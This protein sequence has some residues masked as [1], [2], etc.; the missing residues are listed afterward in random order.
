MSATPIDF[1]PFQLNLRSGQLRRDG[2]PIPL[3]PKTFAVLQHLVE[4]PGEL[5]TKLELLDAVWPGIAVGEDVVRISVGELRVT[6]GDARATPRF[7]ETVP[8]R[9]Y[10]FIAKLG[11]T[12]PASPEL[13][14]T[15]CLDD[16][17]VGRT[18]ER[19][20]IAEWMSVAADR[21]SAARLRHGE[22]RD[23]Q[24]YAR[25]RGHSRSAAVGY[26]E[27]PRRARAMHRAIR[28]RRALQAGPRGPRIEPFAPTPARRMRVIERLAS[29]GID[30]G[31]SIVPMI[32]GFFQP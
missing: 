3:R 16:L 18:H 25:R 26:D 14:P 29:A 1:P 8:R 11:D 21:A 23:R 5:V 2:A 19:A 7:I 31:L 9:G 22:G 17:V 4:R 6:F 13:P 32:L 10:R 24:N 15:D 12:P 27:D 30:V 20:Q 28:R